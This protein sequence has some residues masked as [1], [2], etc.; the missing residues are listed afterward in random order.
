MTKDLD[1]APTALIE[2]TSAVQPARLPGVDQFLDLELPLSVVI[3]R[4]SMQIQDV[5]KLTS[6]SVVELD[7]SVED[8]VELFVHG[9]LVA[10][11]EVVSVNGNYG[12]RV[13]EIIPAQQ[14]L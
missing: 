9:K 10:R 1:E 6:G 2:T 5:L 3:G 14:R 7:R 11:G 8:R 13:T 12:V 4:C